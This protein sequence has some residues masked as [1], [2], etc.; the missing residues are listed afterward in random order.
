[1]PSATPKRQFSSITIASKNAVKP[2]LIL[3]D[4]LIERLSAS[5]FRCSANC[6]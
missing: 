4:N 2:F 3:A 1:M 6:N 5:I